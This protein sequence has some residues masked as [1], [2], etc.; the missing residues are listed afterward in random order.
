MKRVIPDN[1][2]VQEIYDE[3]Y[4][5]TGYEDPTVGLGL[6]HSPDSRYTLE[7]TC[8]RRAHTRLL[9]RDRKNVD[10][11]VNNI[12]EKTGLSKGTALIILERLGI[13]LGEVMR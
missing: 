8:R 5:E 7:L 11:A 6:H 2:K 10:D 9:S 13:W 3:V 12:A 4:R 1:V